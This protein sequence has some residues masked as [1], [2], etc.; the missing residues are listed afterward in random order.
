[1]PGVE[2]ASADPSVKAVVFTGAN[3][4]FSAGADVNDFNTEPTP[5]T[6]TIRD[7][8]AAIEKSDKMFVAAIEK[9]ALGG[10]FELALACDYRIATRRCEAWPSGNQAGFASRA[11]AARS[12]CLV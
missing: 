8:I 10:G 5:E 7:V 6:N 4:I 11:P 1:M 9:N 12:A 3:G 2:A